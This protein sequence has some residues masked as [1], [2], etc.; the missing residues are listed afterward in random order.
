[1]TAIVWISTALGHPSNM[2]P[3]KHSFSNAAQE[4]HGLIWSRRN[5]DGYPLDAEF[6]PQEIW[7]ISSAV[8]RHYKFPHLF[9][10]GNV[11]VVSTAAAAV[12]RRFDL[13]AGALYPVAV[14]KKDRETPVDGEWLCLNFGNRKSAFLPEQSENAYSDYIRNGEKGWFANATLFD[15]DFAV[16]AQA[17]AGPDIWID[18]DVGDAFFLSEALGKALKKENVDKGFFLNK[19]R[20]VVVSAFPETTLDEVFGSMRY[21]GPAL[22]LEEMDAAVVREAKRRTRD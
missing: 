16:S 21:E 17:L 12:L 5:L 9:A 13:G 11:W 6:V 4:K 1:M 18:P 14:M 15:G 22:S 3:L 10:A 7:G 2:R 8:E 19:C 20:V